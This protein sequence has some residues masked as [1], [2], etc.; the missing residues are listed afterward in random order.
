MPKANLGW[1]WLRSKAGRWSY[2]QEGLLLMSPLAQTDTREGMISDLK[3]PVV[4]AG[5]GPVGLAAAIHLLERGLETVIVEAAS[6][7]AESARLG[8]RSPLLAV[9]P[10]CGQ[11]S[12]PTARGRRLEASAS[13]RPSDG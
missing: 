10:Q 13:R 11:N 12:G 7:V 3:L 1:V 9:A 6:E 4:G 8:P 2:A 5:A